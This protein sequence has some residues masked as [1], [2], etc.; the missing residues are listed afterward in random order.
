MEKRIISASLLLFIAV[1]LFCSRDTATPGDPSDNN[2][3]LA[4]VQKRS[5]VQITLDS[6]VQDDNNAEIHIT[7]PSADI[8]WSPPA[9]GI[10][11]VTGY[12]LF[13]RPSTDSGWTMLRR[14][15]SN[16]DTC[17][18]I[19]RTELDTCSDS[20]FYFGVRSVKHNGLKS[21]FNFSSD[22]LWYVLWKK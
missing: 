3:P 16:T 4:S 5:L 17:V 14:D 6:V 18:T 13:F 22:E 19:Y 20:L 21:D 9:E 15:L 1:M 10:D 8:C 11:S 2:E 12:E 7:K